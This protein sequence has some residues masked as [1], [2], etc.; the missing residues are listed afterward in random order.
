[1]G[2]LSRGEKREIIV[3]MDEAG[4]RESAEM[5]PDFYY[6]EQAQQTEFNCVKCGDYNDVRGR[7]AY[8]TSCGWKNN[9]EDLKASL[10]DV[11]E[12]LNAHHLSPAAAVR[13]AVSEFDACCRDFASQVR[14]RIPMKPTRRAALERA[15]HD[16]HASAGTAMRDV[17]DIDLVRG[18]DKGDTTFLKLMMH[19]RHVHEHHGSVADETYVK[20]SGD[21]NA[22]VGV[23]LREDQGNAHRLIGLLNRMVA[24]LEAD[25]HEIFAPT[26]WPVRH[27]NER[28]ERIGR[29]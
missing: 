29:R 19:R 9:R 13:E 25:F 20:E 24:N 4:D 1:M 21:L 2:E 10:E 14:A 26:E 8:C 5:K 16:I 22:R 18:F 28:C 7:F 12:R 3:D 17:A 15:F 6:S 23:L 27:F 11:R